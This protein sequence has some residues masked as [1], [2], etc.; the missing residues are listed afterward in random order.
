MK[1][2]PPDARENK[3]ATR[4]RRGQIGQFSILSITHPVQDDKTAS[5]VWIARHKGFGQ[6]IETGAVDHRTRLANGI[7]QRTS[8]RGAKHVN[9]STLGSVQERLTHITID[10]KLAVFHDLAQLIL[11]I[12]VDIDLRA[13]Q[14]GAGVIAGSPYKSM[15][16]PCVFLPRPTAAK[17]PPRQL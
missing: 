14:A 17:R 6:I 11:P 12:G 4:I 9:L 5:F 3:V 8:R 13:V 1:I 15:R 2:A 16:T 7:D 10:H